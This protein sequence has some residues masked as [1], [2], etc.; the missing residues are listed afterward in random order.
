MVVSFIGLETQEV[1]IKPNVKVV[2]SSDSQALE[3][4]MVVAYGTAKKSSF[5]GSAGTMNAD[6]IATRS[7]SNI[8]NAMSGQV[9][10]VQ[11]TSDNGQ[12]GE[13]AKI[14]IRGIG[15]MASSND[16]LYVVDGVPY[17]GDISSIN[18]SD[19]ESLTVLKDAAANAIYGARGA[20]GVV[21]I[22]TK[23]GQNGEARVTFDA[24]WGSNSRA[25]PNY[26]VISNPGEYYETMF[27]A[28]YNSKAYAG[29]SAADAY[30]YANNTL[31]DAKNGGLGYQVYTVPKGENLIGTNFKLN[32][33]ATLGY[34]DGTYYYTP[35]D[36]YDE[37]FGSSF[38]QE[39]NASVSGKS[40][41][42][43]YY[44][45]AGYLNDTG[46]IQN[47]AFKRYTGRGK[48]D[49]QAKKWLKI[50][51]NL[52]YTY[53][54][55]QAPDNQTSDD[56]SSSG[57]LFFIV[58]SIAPIYPMYVRN[59]DGSIKIDPSTG[60]RVYDAGSTT[61]FSRPSFTGNA[62]RDIELN[63]YHTY[64]DAFSGKWYANITP[65]EGLT[66]T[67]NIAT[68][69]EN[70][71]SN[72]LY[73]TFGSAAATDGEVYVES[74]RTFGVNTQYLASYV[75]TF[76]NV[77][78]F[79][80][81][82]GYEQ[83]R[84]KEQVLY[85][86]NTNTY[87]PNLGEL[88]NAVGTD[89]KTVNSYT[90]NYMTEGILSRIQYNYDGKYF[91]SA[92]YRRDASSYFA[93]ENRWG[94]FWSVG[95]AWILTKEEF[96]KNTSSWLDMLKLKFSVGQ[97]GNDNIGAYAYTDL[98]D[99]V[100]TGDFSM[101]ATFKRMGNPDITWETT[102][103]YN[104]GVEFSLWNGRLSGNLDYY[105]KKTS[106]LLFWLSIPESAGTRG[107]YGNVGD[108]RNMGV[109]LTLTGAIIRTRDIDWTV[110]ANLSHNKTK[111][112]S[113]PESKTAA[114]GGFNETNS[115][116]L[117][118]NW[119]EVGGPLYNAYCIEYAGV[120]EKGEALYWVD[121]ELELA[122][123]PGKNHSSTTTNPN[124]ATYYKQ[125]SILPKVFGGFNTMLRVG[126]FDASLSFDYQIGGKVQDY[127]YAGL[128]TPNETANGAGSAIHKDYI[129]SWS[130]NNTESDIPRWQYGDKYTS[131]S[132][133]D[134]FLTN[135]SYLNFQSFTVG[136]TFPKKWLKGVSKVRI[137]AA[138]ENLCFWSVRKGFDPRYSY[139]G[140]S[141]I[142]PYS[143]AR[144][145]SGGIQMTF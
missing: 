90:D 109:E 80:I 45:S 94:N 76:N 125:G 47:S 26:D 124:E 129:K 60:H 100:P 86:D 91:L 46:L 32:P 144:N 19:I 145:I 8:T 4:V 99:L 83:Y 17:D 73:S 62:A 53:S 102:T 55:S 44:A 51:T 114:M 143:P 75:H 93:K 135:A 136:Y 117:G 65:L 140:N 126:N 2:L 64:T 74:T 88:G 41:K 18:P 34:S 50:G 68:T 89:K 95:A 81:M 3:E 72:N 130:P 13:S 119:F 12:P 6:K 115:T 25:V 39:Y 103:N 20:N 79:D 112:L 97:Q 22:T 1:A 28:L 110:S 27:K 69:L 36:W 122:G 128:M 123:A 107:Y 52:A 48:V 10:G 134:R 54:D 108:I 31:F 120:N 61:N 35:D 82:V 43:S 116:G 105:T 59:A 49:Y 131:F 142:T 104:A 127:R 58:N 24:K 137:Y 101:G 141:S 85:G 40:D 96:L 87:D 29:A 57:N 56:W 77:H 113:L 14:R 15:S 118:G 7:V 132:K 30:A 84:L 33:N 121:D 11:M 5:T 106:D 42:I 78:N 70:T 92:S 71:R 111:I 37:I 23:S 16:P 38:R 138:G 21:L 133:S 63:S 9:A 98:Y 67:A 66:L 139:D